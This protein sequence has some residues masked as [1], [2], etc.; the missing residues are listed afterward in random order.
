VICLR[1]CKLPMHDIARLVALHDADRGCF[2]CL[3]STKSFRDNE[4]RFVHGS[5]APAALKRN[6]LLTHC[7]DCDEEGSTV[8]VVKEG[9]RRSLHQRKFEI[10]FRSKLTLVFPPQYSDEYR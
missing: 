3:R 4:G 9:A 7:L 6:V 5:W 1:V 8:F 10:S 2:G